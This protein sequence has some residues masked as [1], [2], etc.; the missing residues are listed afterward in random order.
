L[1]VSSRAAEAAGR[2]RTL[3]RHSRCQP[4]TPI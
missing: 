3:F 4:L 1:L 2:F